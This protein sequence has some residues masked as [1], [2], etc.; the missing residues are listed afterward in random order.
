[1]T[2][3]D[4]LCDG[5][6]VQDVDSLLRVERDLRRLWGKGPFCPPRETGGCR[7]FPD[8]RGSP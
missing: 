3:E 6:T 4:S 8:R 2:L 1:M 5:E 7:L